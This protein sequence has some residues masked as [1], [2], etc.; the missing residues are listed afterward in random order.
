MGLL[1]LA[2]PGL[3]SDRLPIPTAQEQKKEKGKEK[4]TF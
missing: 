4:G 3:A 2:L 1:M